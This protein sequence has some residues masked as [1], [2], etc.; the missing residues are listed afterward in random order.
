L[1]RRSWG[2]AAMK[3]IGPGSVVYAFNL[4]R[5]RQAGLWVQ[6]QPWTKQVPDLGMVV[7]TVNLGYTICWRPT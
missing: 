2:T 5:L 6:A 7:H 1:T 4:R 3:N